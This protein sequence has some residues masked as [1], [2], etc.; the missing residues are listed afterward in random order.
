MAHVA[1]LH[2][3]ELERQQQ[4]GGEDACETGQAGIFGQRVDE[5]ARLN[6]LPG[7]G[8]DLVERRKQQAVVLEERTAGGLRDG[9]EFLGL[10]F[11]RGGESVGGGVGEFGRARFDD[12][13]HGLAALGEGVVDG[14]VEGGPGLVVFD[15]AADVGIDLEV[16]GN[17]DSRS[18]PRG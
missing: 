1:E 14:V 3:A 16:M 7:G 5:R 6:E 8:L 11:Q 15:E 17:V 4:A 9:D 13:Q 10:A 18:G 12:D 2:L